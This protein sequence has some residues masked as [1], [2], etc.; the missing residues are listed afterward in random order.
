MFTIETYP[1]FHAMTSIVSSRLAPGRSLR[2]RVSALFP[3]GSIVGAPKIRAGEIIRSLEPEPRG[4]Y[5]G[6]LGAIAPNGDMAFNVAIRT[7]VLTADGRGRY[8]VGGGIV[9]D[10][11]PCA[12]Y[13]EALLKGRVLTDLE[14]DYELFETFRWSPGKGFVRL[15]LHLDRLAASA[16]H[17]RFVFD[18]AQAEASLRRMRRT[19]D[20]G[21]ADLR[22]RLAQAR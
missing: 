14:G 11:D 10:S 3:C 13:D 4:F 5:T 15:D 16:R 19:W 9:A 8:D 22:V 12:E 7:A 20:D 18:R 17:L 6:A 2:E 21:T 1:G